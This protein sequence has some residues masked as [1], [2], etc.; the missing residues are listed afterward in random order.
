V[1][2]THA[3]LLEDPGPAA[4]SVRAITQVISAVRTGTPLSPR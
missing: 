3:G 4:E 1:D 2:S